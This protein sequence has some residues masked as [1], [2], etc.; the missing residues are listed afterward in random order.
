MGTKNNP[1]KFDCYANA[2]PDE[3]IFIL[4]GRDY[5]GYRAVLKWAKDREDL[6]NMGL[7]PES[8]RE[9]VAEAR[10]C[11]EQMRIYYQRRQD[12]IHG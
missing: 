12:M 4:L 1:G 7:K 2:E 3:P 10:E 8:D 11:A 6:I 5:H 9:I